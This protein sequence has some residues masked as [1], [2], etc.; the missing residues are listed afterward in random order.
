ML[1]STLS[2]LFPACLFPLFWFVPLVSPTLLQFPTYLHTIDCFTRCS[3]SPRPLF[4]I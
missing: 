1:K 2:L 3:N 4:G